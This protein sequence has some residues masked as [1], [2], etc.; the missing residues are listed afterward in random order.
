MQ[1]GRTICPPD[2]TDVSRGTADMEPLVTLVTGASIL[3]ELILSG[4]ELHDREYYSTAAC[5]RD[6]TFT[7]IIIII[8]HYYY[9]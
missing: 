8:I 2:L 9:S 4:V 5:A 3:L 1:F 6:C 7:K